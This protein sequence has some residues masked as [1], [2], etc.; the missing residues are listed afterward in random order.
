[1]I[2]IVTIQ[3]QQFKISPQQ[4]VYVHRIQA[5]E[6]DVLELNSVMLVED[7]DQVRIGQPYLTDTKV[8]IKVL[9]HLKGDKVLVFKKK[10]RKGYQKMN[11][12]RQSFSKILVES[13]G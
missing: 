4:N 5:S 13:I 8:R 11:G 9:S 7:Q 6:G 3:G 1:M 10:R 2:A 12:H